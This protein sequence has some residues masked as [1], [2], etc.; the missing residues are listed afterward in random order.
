MP[1]RNSASDALLAHSVLGVDGAGLL[2]DNELAEAEE[3]AEAELEQ[4]R[5]GAACGARWCRGNKT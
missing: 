3:G 4:R 1:M 2:T 5:R